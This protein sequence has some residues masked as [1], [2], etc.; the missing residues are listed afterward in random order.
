MNELIEMLTLNRAAALVGA[1]TRFLLILIAAYGVSAVLRRLISKRRKQIVGIMQRGAGGS[2]VELD[3][4]ATTL[5]T[6]I[7]KAAVLSIWLV[8]IVM[9][10]KELGFDIAPILAGAGV[11]GLAVGFG[12][13]NLVRDVITGVFMLVENQVR[14]G[15]VAVMNGTGGLVE[16]VNLRTTVLRSVDGTVHV[17]PNG[18]VNSLS[19]MT[20]EYSFYVFDLDVDYKEDT[21][22]VVETI[23]AVGAQMRQE[24]PYKAEII[25]EVEVFG[26]DRFAESS[27]VIK[28]RIKTR[29]IK[30]WMVGREFNRRIKKRFDELG[31]EIPFPHRSLYFGESNSAFALSF[32][33]SAPNKIKDLVREVLEETR[34]GATRDSLT[35]SPSLPGGDV[36][37]RKS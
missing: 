12:A 5:I 8:A 25:E 17:F 11:V 34:S 30:Q 23:K 20:R 14:V 27:V 15:D 13:Q 19:N 6:I 28:G 32:D 36:A 24:E 35:G 16:E 9:A 18:S 26:V 29:P 3:K 31:I 37:G 22:R 7:R 10:L 1:L 4:R 21:D 33:G 2:E